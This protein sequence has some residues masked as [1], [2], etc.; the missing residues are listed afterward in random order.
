MSDYKNHYENSGS[1]YDNN[2]DDKSHHNRE[3]ECKQGPPGPK[4]DTGCPGPKGDMG[5]TGPRGPKGC[6]GEPGPKGIPGERG[7]K[8]D[9]GCPGA[10]GMRGPVGPEGPRGCQGAKGEQGH[11]GPQGIEGEP[12]PQGPAGPAG[13]SGQNG[14]I[15]DT[16]PQGI[17][18]DDGLTPSIGSNG[19][20]WIGTTDTEVF[21]GGKWLDYINQITLTIPTV[22]GLNTDSSFFYSDGY[23]VVFS[24][25]GELYPNT[26]LSVNTN[27]LTIP[28]NL[29]PSK[30]MQALSTITL[31][32]DS[33][34][35]T[36]S[37]SAS[38]ITSGIIVT[39]N[40]FNYVASELTDNGHW[41]LAGEYFINTV[42]QA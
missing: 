19:N 15:G 2:C 40:G 17:Q 6:P 9:R 11:I 27:I 37:G 31:I 28:A 10:P 35:G 24:L 32:E 16:G 3:R 1:R 26:S 13:P 12:G 5:D 20:W 33:N 41:V 14:E 22:L 23:R 39:D 29:A 25:F 38:I 36:V 18:G 4:G 42:P 8:G 21:A 7:P 34:I 30:D